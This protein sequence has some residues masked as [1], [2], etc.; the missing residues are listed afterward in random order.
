MPEEP[1]GGGGGLVL[2]VVTLLWRVEARGGN[3]LDGLVVSAR[4]MRHTGARGQVCDGA[5]SAPVDG[6]PGRR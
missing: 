1:A 4:A 2:E 5:S 6:S 3:K